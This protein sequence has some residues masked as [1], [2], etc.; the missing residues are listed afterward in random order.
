MQF[1]IVIVGGGVVG[2]TLANLLEQANLNY[3]IAIVDATFSGGEE[4]GKSI[5][6]G[7]TT[8]AV[9]KQINAL[10]DNSHPIEKT[11]ISF[12]VGRRRSIGQSNPSQPLGYAV[13]LSTIKQRLGQNLSSV[14]KI[15]E[16]VAG[17]KEVDGHARLTTESGEVLVCRWAFFCCE[18]PCELPAINRFSYRYRQTI[19]YT[20]AQAD[21][22]EANT[23]HQ[24]YC[25]NGVLVLVPRVDERV[26]II[27]CFAKTVAPKIAA[28]LEDEFSSYIANELQCRITAIGKRHYYTPYVKTAKTLA[29]N[30]WV[31]LGQ[32]ATV[33]HPIGAQ[34]LGLGVADAQTLV[35]LLAA[36]LPPQEISR[37]YGKIRL[38]MHKK[39]ILSTSGMALA[40]HLR[41]PPFHAMADFITQALKFDAPQRFVLKQLS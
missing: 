8:A 1:D 10:P 23:A 40:V 15:A 25:K 4:T 33:L 21:G 29:K 2:L 35:Q 39:I 17:Y 18:V 30:N 31:L 22:W 20:H 12:G 19:V 9:L 5:V 37:Q 13:D 16:R 32:G 34:S 6:I 24:R 38:K 28:M 36:K 26:G 7:H 41:T 3:S 11:Y 14:Q 27:G